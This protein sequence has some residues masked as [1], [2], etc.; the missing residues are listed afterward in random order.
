M[1]CYSR[2]NLICGICCALVVLNFYSIAAAQTSATSRPSDFLSPSKP[3]PAGLW[4]A[5][6]YGGFEVQ[7]GGGYRETLGLGTAGVNYY[8]ADNYSL[9]AELTGLGATQSG[10]NAVAGGGDF[11]LRSHLLVRPQWSLFADFSLGAMQ[12]SHRLPPGGT[13]F[14]F[15]TETSLGATIHLWDRTELMAG[16]KY[17]H[18]S[19]ARQEGSSR[20]PSINAIGAYAGLM[21]RF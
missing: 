2:L 4:T 18:L 7:P 9:G 10:V 3:F 8:F 6:T 5:A 20:N 14:N 15:T 1:G 13:D 11:I 12:A 19:N 21:F 17:L 16:I